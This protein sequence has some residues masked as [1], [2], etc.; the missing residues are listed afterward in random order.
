YVYD[1]QSL[2]RNK[3]YLRDKLD[4]SKFTEEEKNK[5]ALKTFLDLNRYSFAIKCRMNNDYEN[6]FR[7]KKDIIL[8]NLTLR[9]RILLLTPA[10]LLRFLLKVN[11][12]LVQL[13]ISKS[14]FKG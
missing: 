12:I 13:G 7:F 6:Y 2:S 11:L 5:H 4:F 10:F 14:V 8:Q 3:A 9:K 1:P